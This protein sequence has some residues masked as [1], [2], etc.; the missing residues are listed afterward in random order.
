MAQVMIKCPRT[1]KYLA[2]KF[3][4]DPAAFEACSFENN[5]VRCPHCG[6]LHVWGKRDAH[7]IEEQVSREDPAS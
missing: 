7:L 3:E 6:E 5:G 1:Q 4:I 2:V